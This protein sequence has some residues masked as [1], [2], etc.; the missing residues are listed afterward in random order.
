LF[1]FLTG[2]AIINIPAPLIAAS[3]NESWICIV[4]ACA[5]GLLILPPLVALS[6]RYPGMNYL[7]IASRIVGKPVAWAI[8]LIFLFYQLH[9][10]AAIVMDIAL[11][12]K[13]SMMRATEYS[14]FIAWTFFALVLTVRIGIGRFAGMF[15]LLMLSVMVFIAF[16][17]VLAAH[18]FHPEFLLPVLD[19]GFKPLLHG[20]YFM[21]GFPYVEIVLFGMVLP[22]VRF[23]RSDR[24]GAKLALAVL[25]NAAS[26]AMVTLATMMVFGPIAG[27]RKYSMYEVSRT[28]EIT[29][30]FQRI[31]A[32]MGYSMIVASFMKA[33]IVLFTL[34]QTLNQLFGIPADN[35]QLLFPLGLLC[36]VISITVGLRGEADWS[37]IVSGVHPVWG[38]LGTLIPFLLVLAVSLFRKKRA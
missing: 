30:I 32:L 29:E 6:G 2:S 7:Q 5:L 22:F 18:R 14:L 11:F 33:A 24:I 9:M 37:F 34:H 16:I 38:V 35:R 31:E 21:F 4:V 28:V 8:G 12:L 20:T 27:E 15:G 36:A 25:M 10:V 13:S 1:V 26:L 19:G 17:V 23:K 3:R